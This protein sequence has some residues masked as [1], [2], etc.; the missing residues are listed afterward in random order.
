M[1]S[2]DLKVTKKV[3]PPNGSPKNSI[4]LLEGTKSHD[5]LG[6][7]NRRFSMP[8]I[9]DARPDD[10][11]RGRKIEYSPKPSSDKHSHSAGEHREIKSVLNHSPGPKLRGSAGKEKEKEKDRKYGRSFVSRSHIQSSEMA[12]LD[13]DED[14]DDDFAVITALLRNSQVI[15]AFTPNTNDH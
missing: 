13:D 8:K 9:S 12:N 2:L 10:S 1:P 3:T 4:L 11:S 7:V 6:R 5:D 15:L 14:T